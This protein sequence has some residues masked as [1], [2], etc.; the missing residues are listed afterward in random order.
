LIVQIIQAALPTDANAPGI[1]ATT[2]ALDSINSKNGQKV[3]RLKNG[4]KVSTENVVA[5]QQQM[6]ASPFKT[7]FYT[8]TGSDRI[9]PCPICG[10]EGTSLVALDHVGKCYGCGKVTLE[11]L[12]NELFQ[13]IRAREG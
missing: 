9:S 10:R 1:T 7:L 6:C 2:R 12:C 13:P 3:R 4:Q 8:L 5:L 11:Q